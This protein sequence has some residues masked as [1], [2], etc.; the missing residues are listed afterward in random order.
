MNFKSYRYLDSVSN[1]FAS[2]KTSDHLSLT[3]VHLPELQLSLSSGDGGWENKSIRNKNLY[4]VEISEKKKN[5]ISSDTKY[6]RNGWSMLVG[7]NG[8]KR[9]SL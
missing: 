5:L 3:Q 9:Y 4:Y 6:K 7:D 1:V 8:L 2:K